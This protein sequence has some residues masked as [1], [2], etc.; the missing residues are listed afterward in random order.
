LGPE[1]RQ[2]LA[3]RRTLA[4]LVRLPGQRA[5]ADPVRLLGRR[6]LAD[7]AWVGRIPRL[8]AP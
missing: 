7:P 5:L 3:V 1:A 4:D 8:P 6:A 2:D